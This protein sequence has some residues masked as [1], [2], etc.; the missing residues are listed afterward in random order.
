[1]VTKER[2]GDFSVTH[3][4]ASGA[5]LVRITADGDLLT[6]D[7]VAQLISEPDSRAI[8]IV[9]LTECQFLDSGAL[10]V[11]I[12]AHKVRGAH[13]RV[14][15]PTRARARRLFDITNMQSTFLMETRVED[16][17]K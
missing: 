4:D 14:E 13:L 11:L 9:D 6:A 8:V 15:V 5:S 3:D 7:K 12:H 2:G 17:L 10:A 1:M 16:A